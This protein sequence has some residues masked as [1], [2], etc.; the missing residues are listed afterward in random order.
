MKA[1]KVIVYILVTGTFPSVSQGFG[2][3]LFFIF[4]SPFSGQISTSGSHYLALQAHPPAGEGIACKE[5][6]RNIQG[7]T[8][9]ALSPSPDFLWHPRGSI[10][11][12]IQEHLAEWSQH[13]SFYFSPVSPLPNTQKP[14]V[15]KTNKQLI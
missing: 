15:C 13:S 14:E 2:Y 7:C 9:F 4:F 11:K 1:Y 8:Q 12:T 5:L 6:L 3:F 10:M